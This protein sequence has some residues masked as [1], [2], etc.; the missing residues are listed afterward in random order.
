MF[1]REKWPVEQVTPPNGAQMIMVLSIAFEGEEDLHLLDDDHVDYLDF[2]ERNYE[3]RR[4]IWRVIETLAKHEV[5][6][7]F[8]IP[9]AILENY[10]QACTA[11]AAQ[12]NEMAAHSYH[13]EHFERMSAE[14]EVESFRRMMG[15]FEDL[16]ARRPEGFRTCFPSKRTIDNVLDFGFKYDTSHRDDDMPYMLEW[17]DGRTLLEIPR[18]VNGDGHVIG[19][20]PTPQSLGLNSGK[21]ANPRRAAEHWKAEFAACHER[22]ENS[23]TMMGLTLHPFCSGHP[24]SMRAVDDFLAYARGFS[25]VWWATQ[26][27]IADLWLAATYEDGRERSATAYSGLSSHVSE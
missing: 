3:P 9:G 22:G 7:T 21:L 8:V 26:T 24:S 4:A 19:T 10:P 18:N 16:F 2:Y 27:E 11:A 6:A 23:P 12:G 5:R 25:N 15:A 1:E 17:A 14:E 20:P 13:H